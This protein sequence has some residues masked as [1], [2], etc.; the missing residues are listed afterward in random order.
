[1]SNH[2]SLRTALLAA[3]KIDDGEASHEAAADA[4]AAVLCAFADAVRGEP[5]AII[6]EELVADDIQHQVL[7][8]L[9]ELIHEIRAY[10]QELARAMGQLRR[11]PS[12]SLG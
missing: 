4:L 5:V 9:R 3:F 6:S 10:R 8:E 7:V 2:H 11:V 12:D 1:M